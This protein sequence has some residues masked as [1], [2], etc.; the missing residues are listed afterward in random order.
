M[1]QGSSLWMAF[2]HYRA[3]LPVT[4]LK[5]FL[6]DPSRSD[7]L[8]RTVTPFWQQQLGY[9]Q[10]MIDDLAAKARAGHVPLMLVFVPLRSQAVLL[11]HQDAFPNEDPLALDRAVHAM[12]ARAGVRF[13]DFTPTLAAA[14]DINPLYFALD[15]PCDGARQRCCWPSN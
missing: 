15:E 3:D 8:E 7:Y 5:F 4:Y 1:V 2:L 14:P 10:T 6:R 12:A 9:T 13:M 11:K